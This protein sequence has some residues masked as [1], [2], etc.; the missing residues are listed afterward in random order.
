MRKA[1]LLVAS[2]LLFG[3]SVMAQGIQ[4]VHPDNTPVQVGLGYTF[5]S[6]HEVPGT[7][8]NSVGF[9]GSAVYRL[10]QVGLEGEVTDALCSENGKM[11]QLFFTGGGARFFVP[12]YGSLHPWVHAEVGSA[13]LSPAASFGTSHSLGYKA[14]GGFDFNP[15]RSRVEY[16]VAADVLG[17]NFFGTYQVSPQVSVSVVFAIGRN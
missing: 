16:R 11:T 13:N 5:V 12:Y 10:N 17:T 6:F 15:Y 3:T 8:A 2:F 4:G 14:G 9:T 1:I 7:L